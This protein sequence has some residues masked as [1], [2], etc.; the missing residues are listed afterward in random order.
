MRRN[1]KHL[2]DEEVI[3]IQSE[4]ENR[5]FKPGISDKDISAG[6]INC[7]SCFQNSLNAAIYIKMDLVT[8]SSH[9]CQ[10]TFGFLNYNCK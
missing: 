4:T 10:F 8:P 7:P 6:F 1:N 2:N 9:Y 5:G 3:I